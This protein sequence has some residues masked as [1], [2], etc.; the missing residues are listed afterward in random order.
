MKKLASPPLYAQAAAPGQELPASEDI[1]LHRLS[2]N[3]R[4]VLWAARCL[5][6]SSKGG[7][8]ANFTGYLVELAGAPATLHFVGRRGWRS[9]A[10]TL[11][12]GG[13]KVVQEARFLSEDLTL[14]HPVRDNR[15][16]FVFDRSRVRLVGDLVARI[17]AGM[18]APAAAQA[19]D[20]PP[21]AVPVAGEVVTGQVGR[22][23]Q[24]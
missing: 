10:R 17:R 2:P 6:G 1:Q 7:L 18:T 22:W 9:V 23:Q 12:V 20:S 14:Y 21:D 15:Q 19:G 4:K 11:E 24:A 8:P 13:W 3:S 16:V 5:T